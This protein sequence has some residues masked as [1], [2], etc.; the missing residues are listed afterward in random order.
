MDGSGCLNSAAYRYVPGVGWGHPSAGGSS[1]RL[2]EVPRLG[3]VRMY[4]V[5][6]LGRVVEAGG[7]AG[8]RARNFQMSRASTLVQK[9]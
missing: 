9:N 4:V 6:V 8:G 3:E 2:G 7:R 5:V 1:K